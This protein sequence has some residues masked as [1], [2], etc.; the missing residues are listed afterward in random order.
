MPSIT[1]RAFGSTGLQVSA[2][3][4]GAGHIGG[5]ELSEEQAAQLLSAALDMGITFIDTARGYGLSEERIGRHLSGRRASF[6]LSSKGG[7][8]VDGAVDWTAEAVTLGIDGALGR[9]R[10]D[11]IDVFHL[12]SCPRDVLERGEVPEALTRAREAGKIRVCA[13]SG[14]ND[15]LSWAIDSGIFGSVQCSVN[16]CD[17]RSIVG[18]VARARARSLGVVAKRPLANFAWRFADRPG[19][20]YA[21]TY[22][23]RLR[24]MQATPGGAE[25]PFG[26]SW[27]ELALR[28][29]A[30]APGVSSAIVGTRSLAHL[31]ASREI[32]ARGPLP[33]DLFA[34]LRSVFDSCDSGWEGQI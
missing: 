32:V 20:D 13:Y 31:R 19:G 14:E 3:G 16:L 4:F 1:P 30:F 25:L 18:G 9:L 12:H 33:A 22:W 34:R 10:T 2:L 23:G 26:L 17:Q 5:S 15:A 6:V 27:P 11:V 7:Y 21:E 8:G 28:F 29:S 24:A